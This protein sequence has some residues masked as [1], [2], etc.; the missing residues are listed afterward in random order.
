MH[1]DS[2]ADLRRLFPSPPA[3]ERWSRWFW[4]IGLPMGLSAMI[5]PAL[6]LAMAQDADAIPSQL[7]IVAVSGILGALLRNCR[8]SPTNGVVSGDWRAHPVVASALCRITTALDRGVERGEL[9][10]L[11]AR[12]GLEVTR[13]GRCALTLSSGS[14]VLVDRE[15]IRWQE[16]SEAES[17][18]SRR[19]ISEGNS[20]ELRMPLSVLGEVLGMLEVWSRPGHC[21]GAKEEALLAAFC[22]EA[23]PAIKNLSMLSSAR[24]SATILQT[25]ISEM[26]WW[27][28]QIDSYARDL[29]QTH[30]ELHEVRSTLEET[31][32]A[33]LEALANAVDARDPYTYG[34]CQRVAALASLLG[35]ETGLPEQDLRILERAAL[36]HDIGKLAVPDTILRKTTPLTS[37]DWSAI[38]HHPELGFRMLSG[39]KFLG[40]AL[41]AIRY[42]HE[43]FDGTG[44]PYKLAGTQ[45]PLMARILAVADAYDAITSDRPYRP[46]RSRVEGLAEVSRGVGSQFDP[47]MAGAL[48]RVLGRLGE[49]GPSGRSLV[50]SGVG[51]GE[52]WEAVGDGTQDNRKEIP[53]PSPHPGLGC[54]GSS[55]SASGSVRQRP[56]VPTV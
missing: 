44:Y 41:T 4:A 13:G 16:T 15:G 21:L 9:L 50:R 47:E 26:E 36:L 34:H 48:A 37:D 32:M 35:A 29:E 25:K 6:V 55:V 52:L 14:R 7:L 11:I 28:N 46:G 19:S 43:R 2:A 12:C 24:V 31:Y 17:H 40:D 39:L 18:R 20:P 45:I 1:L 22:G 56:G 49:C 33:T 51:P 42:H 10:E 30:R 54:V 38:Q 23:A 5:L 3:H 8:P 53:V 27:Q